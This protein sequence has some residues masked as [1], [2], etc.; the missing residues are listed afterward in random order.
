MSEMIYEDV[1]RI[2]SEGRLKETKSKIEE[3]LVNAQ[4]RKPAVLILDGL[5]S[6]LGPEHEVSQL[7]EALV[8]PQA[9]MVVDTIHKSHYTR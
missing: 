9:D 5:D 8:W 3:L 6:L 4:R 7:S 1:A 2:D